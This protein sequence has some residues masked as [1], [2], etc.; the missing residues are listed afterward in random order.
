MA[1]TGFVQHPLCVR[2]DT[3]PG[4]PERPERLRAIERRLE[5]AGILS[6]VVRHEA[7]EASAA[8]IEAVHVAG[9]TA[10]F[11]ALCAE[12]PRNL[13]GDT[14]VSVD[15]Y[16]ALL[17]AA[18]GALDAVQ[19]V[20]SGTW[21]NAFCALRP[22][23]HHAEED[24]AMGFCL[25]NNVAIAARYLQRELDFERIAILD[26]DVHHGNG[27]QH[28]FEDDASVF[29]ASLH[30]YP[31]YPGT[32]AADER[33]RGNGEGATLNCPLP[34]GTRNADWIDAL[35]THVLPAFESFAP[36]FVLISAGFDAHRRDPLSG[37]ELDEEGFAV[38]T[39][40]VLDFASSTCG[41]RVVSLLEGGYDLE[42]LAGSV[43]AHMRELLA[44]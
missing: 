16:G 12:G 27:T 40:R 2:H 28:L 15:S 5:G 3:G 31:H 26:W 37:I 20:A 34:S 19:K 21:T 1:T 44:G 32:G 25:V 11:A 36:Q 42:G 10:R 29:Y 41:G 8:E 7:R 22:P 14:A 4:H 23:G 35:E 6:E 13:D 9:T 43:E 24:H 38:L 17:R 39:R 30:Q 33:G 18:G